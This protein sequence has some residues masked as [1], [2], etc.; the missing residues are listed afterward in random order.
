MNIGLK[1]TQIN[2]WKNH[3]LRNKTA[4]NVLV[5]LT[6]GE[7][8]YLKFSETK[9]NYVVWGQKLCDWFNIAR[10]LRNS[11]QE[12]GN[13]KELRK[14]ISGSKLYKINNLEE[15]E[16]EYGSLDLEEYNKVFKKQY[17]MGYYYDQQ[18]EE[19]SV[20][21]EKLDCASDDIKR[22]YGINRP[23]DEE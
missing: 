22:N 7:T 12:K 20:S 15:E 8:T 17:T 23:M 9:I 10:I 13:N 1:N 11:L 5:T 14:S 19:K 18:G 2:G 16:K 6:D 4:G 21:R 3:I